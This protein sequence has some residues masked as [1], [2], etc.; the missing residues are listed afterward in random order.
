MLLLDENSET[1]QR[2]GTFLP[3]RV[4]Y[5]NEEVIKASSIFLVSICLSI[6]LVELLSLVMASDCR[7]PI[8]LPLTYVRLMMGWNHWTKLMSFQS[9]FRLEEP[10]M[11]LAG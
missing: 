9:S 6:S 8:A 11:L 4:S 1:Q 10:L 7:N 3:G 5:C 2:S